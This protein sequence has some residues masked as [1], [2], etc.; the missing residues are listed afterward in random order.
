MLE[1]GWLSAT[2]I[3]KKYA[4]AIVVFFLN[5]DFKAKLPFWCVLIGMHV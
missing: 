3:F 4:N 2:T 5:V 1:R